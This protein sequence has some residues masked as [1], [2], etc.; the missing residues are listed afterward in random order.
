[1]DDL[2]ALLIV[3]FVAVVAVVTIVWTRQR[4]NTLIE[5]WA[6]ANGYHL[7]GREPRYLR[8]GPY[9]WRHSRSQQ[10]YYVTITDASGRSRAAYLRLGHW[11]FGL[12]SD[13]LD[14][15]WED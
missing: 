6:A 7:T 13:T 9:F 1:M 4:A 11:F 10:I 2:L 5:R 15:T 8:T 3:F 12:F 14:V